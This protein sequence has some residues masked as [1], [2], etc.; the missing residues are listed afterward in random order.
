MKAP[1]IIVKFKNLGFDRVYPPE[2]D[3]KGAI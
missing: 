2:A 3:L 1:T